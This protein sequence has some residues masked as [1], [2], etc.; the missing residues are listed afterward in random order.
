MRGTY[1]LL[2]MEA[3]CCGD[4]YHSTLAQTYNMLGIRTRG[5]VEMTYFA[6]VASAYP[7][8]PCDPIVGVWLKVSGAG[9]PPGRHDQDA[10]LGRVVNQVWCVTGQKKPYSS[11]TENS[12]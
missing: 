3:T 4:Q 9:V 5:K 6:I 12:C 8:D 7:S 2:T 11:P 1:K 10:S